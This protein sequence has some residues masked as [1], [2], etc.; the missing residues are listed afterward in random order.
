MLQAQNV[1]Q[2][3]A[4][5][6]RVKT[7]NSSLNRVEPGAVA[8]SFGGRTS[9]SQ[10]AN[11]GW[12]CIVH[13]V[14]PRSPQNSYSQVLLRILLLFPDPKLVNPEAFELS[15]IVPKV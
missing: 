5:H 3:C 10:S 6:S 11:S 12:P 1:S 9:F 13:R 8:Q 7:F 4:E 2:A 15:T 14:D